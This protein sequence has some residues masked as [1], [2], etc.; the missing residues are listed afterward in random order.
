M[1]TYFPVQPSQLDKIL[2]ILNS[3]MIYV[4]KR[5]KFLR[6]IVIVDMMAFNNSK[7][8][9]EL[10]THSVA[11]L[12]MFMTT[13]GLAPGHVE[14]WITIANIKGLN[15]TNMSGKIKEVFSPLKEANK[16]R[17]TKLFIIN[18]NWTF[19]AL[20][21]IAKIMIDPL[22]ILKFHVL[23]EEYQNKLLE[24]VDPDCLEEKWGGNLPNKT[25][26][27]FPPELR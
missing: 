9:S 24:T 1:Q 23:G 4:Y 10:L 25:S 21:A 2:E 19:K 16:G 26:N 5:D 22:T 14:N 8:D 15:V 12:M 7:I 17:L 3:G 20:W 13:R 18:S 6:P 11:Y 27:F